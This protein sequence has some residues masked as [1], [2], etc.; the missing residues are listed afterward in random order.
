MIDRTGPVVVTG[1]NGFLGRHICLSLLK[2]GFEVVAIVNRSQNMLDNLASQY[3]RLNIHIFDLVL[4]NESL[5]NLPRPPI[6]LVHAA[7]LDATS[8]S[9]FRPNITMA[10]V[11]SLITR[12]LN[13]PRVVNI[14][15]Q[16]VTFVKRG[17]YASS[18]LIA[19]KI[20]E[21]VLHDRVVHTLR[22]TLIYDDSGNKFVEQLISLG[23]RV[24]MVPIL[25]FKDPKLQPVHASDVASV[26]TQ[27][28][29]FSNIF[30]DVFRF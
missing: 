12:L 30:P 24:R 22:P 29:S 27:L 21:E 28:V 3:S 26:V 17:N 8:T 6:A 10:R 18:K 20:F 5:P 23:R 11:V 1:A 9:D 15:S 13:I 2:E 25:G 7:G 16:N 14:S 4:A 19:E